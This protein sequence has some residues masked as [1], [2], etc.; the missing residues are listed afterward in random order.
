MSYADVA[1]IINMNSTASQTIGQYFVAARNIP[2]GNIIYVQ[3]DTSEEIDSTMF[4]MLRS[5]IENQLILNNIR[6]SVNYLVTTKGVPLKVNR[7]DTYSQNAPSSSVES[8]LMLILGT[9]AV[10]V[11]GPGS[12]MS[13]YF[14]Q[15][16][17]FS[18]AAY[19]MYLVTRLD[20][21][22]VSDVL[23]L[24]DRSG[25]NV[26]VNPQSVFLFD[27]DPAWSS[28]L[29]MYMSTAKTALEGRGR[30][31]SLDATATYQTNKQNLIGYVSWGS[32]DHYQYMYTQNAIPHNSYV[33]GAI[34][35]TYVS[36]SGRSFNNPPAYGQSLIADLISEGV[37]GVKGYVY[38][39]YSNAMAHAYILFDRYAAGYN[40]A[41]SYF[42]ASL[43]VSWMDVVIGDPKTSIVFSPE[44]LPVQLAHFGGTFTPQT[45]AIIFSWRTISEINNYGFV[46]Q[47]ADT[48][49]TN[50]IDI[51]NSFVAGHGTTLIPQQYAWELHTAPA[52]THSFRL[53]QI[54]LDGTEHFS[55]QIRVTTSSLS[56]VEGGVAVKKFDLAQNYPN[57][58]NPSTHVRFT[59]AKSGFVSLKVYNV[60]G[61]EVATVVN[62][63]KSPG[64]Y[65][66][67][68]NASG[69]SSGV[70][71]YRIQA[72]EFVETK[73][74]TLLK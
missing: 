45:S 44:L 72:G 73:R 32:N 41:E 23:N 47:Q 24:I 57:P 49:S 42:M 65:D 22:T 58:F 43:L 66:T 61:R 9:N 20:G 21:Y 55:D 3:A 17:H 63:V 13:P 69:L 74:M 25:P 67:Q 16:A 36:T 68:F 33:R 40:L 54:D 15:N 53:R 56:S 48:G 37:S 10:A 29:N 5:Q 11:G 26:A 18:R 31:V 70:Y 52:G 46:L 1:V 28:P 62:E 6:D 39:P 14:Y 50:F 2:S 19:G 30:V 27:Q 12:Q 35:E 7:G 59:V 34:A 60:E 38:E 71:Y 64:E 4:N 8:D 51:Q